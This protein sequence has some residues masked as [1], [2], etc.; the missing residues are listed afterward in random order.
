[1]TSRPRVSKRQRGKGRGALGWAGLCREKGSG[2]ETELGLGARLGEA[3]GFGVFFL[4]FLY[5][6]SLFLLKTKAKSID[7]KINLNFSP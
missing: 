2:H 3:Q 5:F 4:S 6:L 1:M 7:S